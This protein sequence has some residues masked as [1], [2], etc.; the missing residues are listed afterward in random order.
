MDALI[1]AGGLA[2]R[3]GGQ[4]KALLTLGDRTFIERIIETVAPVVSSVIVSTNQPE[5]YRHL[6]VRLVADAEPGSGPLAGLHAGLQASG[7]D[8]CFVTAADAPLLQAGL[9]RALCALVT[10]AAECDAA[11]PVWGGSVEPLCA[12]YARRCLPAI[13][14]CLD[15]GRIV[16]F[17]PFVRVRYLPEEEVRAV[18]PRGLSFTNVNTPE[19]LRLLRELEGDLTPF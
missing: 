3:M 14:R 17:Y 11:V 2:R 12:V 15:Q 9:V 16:S 10:P 4:A 1:L 8:A 19:D 18:D 6:A 7:A 13:E 5:L